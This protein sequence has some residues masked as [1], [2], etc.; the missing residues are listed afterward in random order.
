M[1]NP[2]VMEAKDEKAYKMQIP[3]KIAIILRRMSTLIKSISN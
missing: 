3:S 2:T 1:I